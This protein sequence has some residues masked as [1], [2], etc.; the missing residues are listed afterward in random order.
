MY[1]NVFFSPTGTT[2][3]V[4]KYAG[5]QLSCKKDVDLSKMDMPEYSMAAEDLCVVGVPS[6]GGRVPRT[7]AERLRKLKGNH[8]PAFLIVTY[9]GRAY[10]DTLKEL[11][12][13]LEEQGFV[14]IGAVAMV[15]EHSIARSMEA[16]RPSKADY[17]DLD[18]FLTEIEHRIQIGPRSIDVP[19]NVPYREYH[20]LP[21]DMQTSDAC[22][23]CGICARGCPTGAISYDD[24]KRIDEKKC[25]SCMRCVTICPAKAKIADPAKVQ[26]LTEKLKPICQPDK[27]NVLF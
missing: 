18:R 15:T 13:L 23:G 25:I 20:V 4:V 1:Y 16:G 2:E 14:C 24:P 8:T 9:G 10:E 21:I 22:T 11:K 3:K 12:D 27:A 5:K 17:R 6:F 7:A 19:G 26:M